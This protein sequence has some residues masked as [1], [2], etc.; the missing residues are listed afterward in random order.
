MAFTL[1]NKC[2]KNCCKWTILVQVII[3]DIVT[4]FFGT[5]CISLWSCRS[6]PKVLFMGQNFI[7]WRFEPQSL[8]GT[9]FT[10]AKGTSLRGMTF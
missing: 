1:S 9:S 6:C 10:H 7:F 8:R 3:V 2:A 5:Q 4:C